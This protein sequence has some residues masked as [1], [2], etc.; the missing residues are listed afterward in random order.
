MRASMAAAS[1]GSRWVFGIAMTR[2]ISIEGD[3]GVWTA[4]AYH[5][6]RPDRFPT[7]TS[8]PN[9][10]TEHEPYRWFGSR[11]EAKT[12]ADLHK[13]LLPRDE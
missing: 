7:L 2:L 12:W 4:R 10:W 9:G 6:V 1:R 8:G 3:D 11:K 13:H 5:R